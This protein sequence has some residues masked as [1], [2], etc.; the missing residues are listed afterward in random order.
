MPTNS[1]RLDE[2]GQAPSG[3]TLQQAPGQNP[4]AAPASKKSLVARLTQLVGAVT[5]TA[6]LAAAPG[7]NGSDEKSPDTS[8]DPDVT[9]PT[10][11]KFRNNAQLCKARDEQADPE[12]DLKARP[13]GTKTL[14]RFTDNDG[15]PR[16][17]EVCTNGSRGK[18]VPKDKTECTNDNGDMDCTVTLKGPDGQEY[19][20]NVEDTSTITDEAILAV[21]GH[22]TVAELN[23]VYG[24]LHFRGPY[25]VSEIPGHLQVALGLW[26]KDGVPEK[27]PV[28]VKR[29]PRPATTVVRR[30]RG[31]SKI[32]IEQ[33]RRITALE[34]TDENQNA[35]L[36]RG[37]AERG[38]LASYAVQ[39]QTAI[40]RIN[41][42]L[43]NR[44]TRDSHDYEGFGDQVHN[45]QNQ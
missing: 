40:N 10:G 2:S 9:V 15:T 32:D 16:F 21:L 26:K 17:Y 20:Y 44:G 29:P 11:E 25:G 3:E 42:A 36:A 38:R 8:P 22:R 14:I 37:E 24:T 34:R 43:S 23:R 33:N 35:E 12:L 19:V 31:P 13:S 41:E 28:V 6:A 5:A 18:F 1:P 27:K 45:K 39:Q 7:C 4:Q 30:R